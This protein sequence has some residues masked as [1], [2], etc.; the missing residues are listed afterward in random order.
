MFFPENGFYKMPI[1]EL[2]EIRGNFPDAI[3]PS[4]LVRFIKYGTPHV[5]SKPTQATNFG[6]LLHSV[7]LEPETLHNVVFGDFTASECEV[8]SLI[9]KH[10]NLVFVDGKT[11]GTKAWQSAIDAGEGFPVLQTTYNSLSDKEVMLYNGEITSLKI[12]AVL[13][14]SSF[15]D[16]NYTV[17]NIA[18][19][20]LALNMKES[21]QDVS[22]S[23]T[24]SLFQDGSEI[25]GF[26]THPEYGRF[27]LI[28]DMVTQIDNVAVFMEL[29]TTANFNNVITHSRYNEITKYKYDVKFA[30]QHWILS[31]LT[32][33]NVLG[34]FLF[35]EKEPPYRAA[36][37]DYTDEAVDKL[38]TNM[39]ESVFKYRESELNRFK[40]DC[41]H[42][43]IQEV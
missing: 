19:L 28:W 5:K 33:V 1:E 6:K 25:T 17:G 42:H 34:S 7:I 13:G 12:G 32:G 9:F 16:T 3:S 38:V 26:Y 18:D 20:E 23:K 35:L 31:N 29:K 39:L 40:L 24:L 27:I 22:I 14:S 15:S 8:L 43:T 37:I 41:I 21:C 4:S 30:L 36:L 10:Q 2:L 11:K